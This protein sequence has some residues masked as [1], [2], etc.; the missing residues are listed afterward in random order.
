VEEI[1]EGDKSIVFRPNPRLEEDKVILNR[2]RH[3]L[4]LFDNLTLMDKIGLIQEYLSEDFS[5]LVIINN[6]K[7]AQKLYSEIDFQGKTQLL[8]SG[9]NKRDR[10]LIEKEITNSDVSK[11][12]KLLIATQ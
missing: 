6:V 7:T 3:Q 8:H 10:T 1:Y 2:K 12:P 5:V 11:Q 9:F 4:H